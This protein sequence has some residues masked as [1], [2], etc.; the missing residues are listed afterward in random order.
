[1]AST[2]PA[3]PGRPDERHPK[4][5]L[6]S[7]L[8]ARR[9][10]G[11]EAL[12]GRRRGL[13]CHDQ[14][15]RPPS[16]SHLSDATDLASVRLFDREGSSV[17]GTLVHGLAPQDVHLLTEFEGPEYAIKPLSVDAFG[18]PQTLAR[19]QDVDVLSTLPADQ[20]SQKFETQT[21][22][23][24]AGE[25]LLEP[26]PWECVNLLPL[27]L[28][29]AGHLTSCRVACQLRSIHAREAAPLDYSFR[30]AG[31][32]RLRPRPAQILVLQARLRQPQ[33]RLVRL[34]PDPRPE[35]LSR[36]SGAVRELSGQVH[37]E[38]VSAS[39]Y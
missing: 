12:Q 19:G 31:T 34:G 5:R 22:V 39:P 7:L 10:S 33:P 20:S 16:C 28:L 14:L 36:A 8:P 32:T 25:H 38:G 17:R 29:R 27:L 1:M 26:A 21:Y 24:I 13:P 3:A 15:V 11:L 18:S 37:Q 4:R 2:S 6:S 35:V 30:L 9:R 23:W